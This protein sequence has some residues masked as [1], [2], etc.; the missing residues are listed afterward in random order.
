M[1][2]KRG[3]KMPK[4]IIIGLSGKRGSGKTT[5]A[6][7]LE[8]NYGFKLV[9]FAKKLKEYAEIMHPGISK[10]HKEIPRK[11]LGGETPRTYYISLGEHERYYDQ[12]YWLK[13]PK[14]E[15]QTGNIVIDDVRF[16][17]EADFIRKLGG[18]II[19]LNRFERLNVYGKNLDVPSE[20]D[21]D[22]YKFDYVVEDCVN[23]EKKDL[24]KQ[25]DHVIKHIV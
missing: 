24:H 4:Q 16:K 12:D 23:V 14:I 3:A 19:R 2:H 7:Y 1:T 8:E 5:G 25:L 15:D 11:E 13:A 9:S 17:N 10:W 18:K 6:M 22:D 21:L 20:T